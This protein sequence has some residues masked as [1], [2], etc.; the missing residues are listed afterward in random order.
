MTRSGG[1]LG[2]AELGFVAPF[3]SLDDIAFRLEIVSEQQRQIR[4]VLDDEDAG[5]RGGLRTADCLSGLIHAS[6]PAALRSRSMSF[7]GRLCGRSVGI[8]LPVTR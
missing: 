4:F 8:D 1:V 7:S 3:Y 6:P 2:E 5:L